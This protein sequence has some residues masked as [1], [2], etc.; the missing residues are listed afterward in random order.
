[1]F[2]ET[3]FGIIKR[4]YFV[5]KIIEDECKSTNY[6][7]INILDVGCGTGEM[8][9]VELAKTQKKANKNINF[10]AY[11]SDIKS[12]AHLK[13]IC[14]NEQIQNITI[15]TQMPL[16]ELNKYNIIII[17]E[18]LEHVHEPATFL[19]TFSK[20]LAENGKL[21]ITIPNG[22]GLFEMDAMFERILAL[23]GLL[24][25]LKKLLRRKNTISPIKTDT[26]AASPHINFF[27]YRQIKNI[28]SS[29]GLA[30]EKYEGRTFICGCFFSRL[31]D[32]SEKLIKVNSLLGTRLPPQFVSAWM[33]LV[34]LSNAEHPINTI[35]NCSDGMIK[36]QYT[37][38][39]RY[40]N[41]KELNQQSS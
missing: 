13:K 14:E 20:L 40:L 39:K 41:L 24:P 9:T 4:F 16:V 1:M 37:R 30:I 23:S 35:V 36:R 31:I 34:K 25:F 7:A 27:S 3:S 2:I 21:I 15:Y 17:S 38:F 5:N 11:D 26:L 33:F 12:I 10:H 28:I 22:F 6:N 19:N 29:Q 18:V 32:K 8:L